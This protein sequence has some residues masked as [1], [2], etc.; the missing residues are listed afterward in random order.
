MLLDDPA[1]VQVVKVEVGKL[2]AEALAQVGLGAVCDPPQVAHGAAR[3][4]G[5]LRQFMGPN[6]ISASTART[7]SWAGI[8]RP[9]ASPSENRQALTEHVVADLGVF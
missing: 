9:P 7:S 8:D 3:L 2:R 1:R 5:E 6:M 4:S